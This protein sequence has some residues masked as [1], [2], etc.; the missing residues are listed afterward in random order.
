[1]RTHF[2]ASDCPTKRV[3]AMSAY[4][5]QSH[6][7]THL[8]PDT[9]RRKSQ[10]NLLTST[11]KTHHPSRNNMH[12]LSFEQLLDHIGSQAESILDSATKLKRGAPKHKDYLTQ[13]NDSSAEM[14]YTDTRKQGSRSKKAAKAASLRMKVKN[15]ENSRF[16]IKIVK[17]R[18]EKV[19]PTNK[20]VANSLLK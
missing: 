8:P 5:N 17:T 11:S 19:Q 9:R 3:L 20:F 4:H 18:N 13:I 12:N 7:C 10:P 6:I 1:M 2:K 14:C 16:S 15:Q